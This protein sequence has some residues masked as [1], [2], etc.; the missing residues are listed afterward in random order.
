[1]EADYLVYGAAVTAEPEEFGQTVLENLRA[2]LNPLFVAVEW[3]Q[4]KQVKRSIFIS[5]GAVLR[6]STEP[7]LSETTQAPVSGIYAV[8]KQTMESLIHTLHK[9]YAQDFVTIRLGNIYG[10]METSRSTRPRVSKVAMMVRE[11]IETGKLSVSSGSYP[12]DWTN[13]N[14]VG[15]A[16]V[17]LLQTP[18]LHH[19]LYH[20][21][22][23]QSVNDLQIAQAIQE[24]L[25]EVVIEPIER[26]RRQFRGV[27]V[28]GRLKADTGF[29]A[30]IPFA[31][32][33]RQTVQWMQAEREKTQ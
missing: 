20:V 9:E 15:K 28:G 22:S 30:W 6:Y 10:T 31:D 25:P 24:V 18:E 33:I 17:A 12:Q 29:D 11:A 7:V 8:A 14:D 5:S 26:T 16:V 2:N 4:S 32:G 23:S 21:V 1:V 19:D 27:M 13:A 3:T